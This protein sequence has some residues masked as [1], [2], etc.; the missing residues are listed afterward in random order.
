MVADVLHQDMYIYD[1]YTEYLNAIGKYSLN[2]QYNSLSVRYYKQNIPLTTGVHDEIDVIVTNQYDRTYDIFDF[3]PVLEM[4]PLNYSNQNDQSNQGVIRKT[5]GVLTILAVQEPLPGDIFNFY[6]YD[7]TN[8][9]FEVREVNFVYSVKDL[10]I[11]QLNFETANIKKSSVEA[12]NIHK[13]YYYMKEFEKFYSS[14]LYEDYATLI[15]TRNLKLEVISK[16]YDAIQCCYNDKLPSSLKE[17]LNSILVYLNEKIQLNI[18]FIL[19]MPVLRDASGLVIELTLDQ[20]YLADPNYVPQPIDPSIPYDPYIGKI[21]NE[22]LFTVFELQTSY[23]KFIN[24]QQPLDG[25]VDTTGIVQTK[26][27]FEQNSQVRDLD[28]NVL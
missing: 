14:E 11:Y 18:S 6:Q 4:T 20:T 22:L 2:S 9:Y 21:Q 1:I 25:S 16:Y 8:E 23:F 26:N 7:S 13:H 24:Y 3:A 19:N 5:E 27:T 15:E 10:N 12:L 28:G 17:I